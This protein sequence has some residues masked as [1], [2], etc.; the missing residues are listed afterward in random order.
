[1]PLLNYWMTSNQGSKITMPE[2]Q[3]KI[4]NGVNKNIQISIVL[5]LLIIGGAWYLSFSKKNGNPSQGADIALAA[6]FEYLSKN[7]NSSCSG[8]FQNSIATMPVSSPSRIML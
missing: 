5:A 6:K 3:S 2:K 1:M 4:S 7:G 8:V